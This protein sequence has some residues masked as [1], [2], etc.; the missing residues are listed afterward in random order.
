M[1]ID[2]K[3]NKINYCKNCGQE[4]Q[5]VADVNFY[6]EKCGAK[7]YKDGSCE[8]NSSKKELDYMQDRIN[9]FDRSYH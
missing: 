3:I 1:P 9:K 7:N 4:Q 6:C 2:T 8:Y 5:L